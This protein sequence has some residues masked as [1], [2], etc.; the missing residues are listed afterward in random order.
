MAQSRR[1]EQSQ[2]QR[3]SQGEPP[4]VYRMLHSLRGWGHG[5]IESVFPGGAGAS[6][7]DGVRACPGPRIPVG[8]DH[9]AVGSW[10][11]QRPGLA[12][13]VTVTGPKHGDG[14]QARGA[15]RRRAFMLPILSRRRCRYGRMR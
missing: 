15:R 11:G 6:S 5:E 8:G 2:E 3:L 4:R 7:A 1:S 13:Y 9:C 14:T 12:G 10:G